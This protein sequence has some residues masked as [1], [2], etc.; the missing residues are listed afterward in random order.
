MKIM[1][2]N[3]GDQV[4]WEWGNGTASGQIQK[5]YTRKITR[6]IKETEVT[7][8]ADDSNPA[9]YV[10][11]SGGGEVLKSHSEIRKAS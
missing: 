8:D 2:Y 10:E 5:V 7:R 4:E 1:N 3:I 9:Y 11:Q 6:K